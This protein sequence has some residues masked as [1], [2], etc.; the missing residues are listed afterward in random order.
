MVLPAWT[1]RDFRTN[2][3]EDHLRLLS[4]GIA[5]AT[6]LIPGVNT[7]TPRARYHSFYC[8]V[9]DSFLAS[10]EEKN[11]ANFKAHLRKREM[12]FILANIAATPTEEYVPSLIGITRGLE[13]WQLGE[14]PVNVNQVYV[15]NESGGYAIYRGV[16]Q[17][18]HLIEIPDN[19]GSVD[20]IMPKGKELA[21]EFR[22]TIQATEYYRKYQEL[23]MVPRTV[24][25]EYG[26]VA[27]LNNLIGKSDNLPLMEVFLRPDL[28]NKFYDVQRRET[29]GYFLNIIAEI[30]KQMTDKEWRRLLHYAQ[31]PDNT[32]YSAPLEF[33]FVQKGWRVYAIRQYFAY[34]LE[35]LFCNLIEQIRLQSSRLEDFL[36]DR[37]VSQE[38]NIKNNTLYFDTGKS[39]ATFITTIATDIEEDCVS[40]IAGKKFESL[41]PQV[42]FTVPFVL[43]LAV[44][45]QSVELRKD[46]YSWH[47]AGYGAESHISLKKFVF[48]V[49]KL[50]MG[51]SSLA[52]FCRF[53][54]KRYILRQHRETALEKLLGYNLETFRI[55]ENEG[56]LEYRNNYR[57]KFNQFRGYQLIQCM[58]DLG[59]LNNSGQKLK[60]MPLGYEFMEQAKQ[61]AKKVK[62][63]E[64][65]DVPNGTNED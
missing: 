26:Q 19:P 45:N 27:G 39:L 42:H 29:M 48:D 50:L 37:L 7:V 16:M 40:I 36:N 23:D 11:K 30:Q 43:L 1:E 53:I 54:Y 17:V 13:V 58:L 56:M 34:A 21:Q 64:W 46:E 8:W 32:S 52:N 3:G 28:E 57:P 22:K 63:R 2:S 12:A 6:N 9:L 41:D 15:V 60:V 59:L 61:I 10:Q 33:I 35:T 38:I 20:R 65:G 55:V 25:K 51:G 14:E 24:L 62:N 5:L 4:V 18:L 44:Y 47:L 31:K 49:D